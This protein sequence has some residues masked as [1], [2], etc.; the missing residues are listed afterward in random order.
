MADN[1]PIISHKQIW[2]AI[3][4]LATR[5]NLSASGLARLAGLDPTAFNKS[6]RTTSEGRERWPS[7]ESI[8]KVLKATHTSLDEFATLMSGRSEKCG[9]STLRVVPVVGVANNGE[10][11]FFDEPGHTGTTLDVIE[12]PADLGSNVY[13]I[14]VADTG[15]EP[16]YR[17]GDLLIVDRDSRARIGDRVVVKPVSG[18]AVTRTLLKPNDSMLRLGSITKRKRELQINRD[19]VLWMDRIVWASQ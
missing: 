4:S 17:H 14:A 13:G 19:R 18:V 8:A 12:G 1:T 2:N 6:K 9:A 15:M 5:S 16:V 7:T 11:R 3:D 10:I